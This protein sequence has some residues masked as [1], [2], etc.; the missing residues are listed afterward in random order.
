LTFEEISLCRVSFFRSSPSL[1]FPIGRVFEVEDQFNG[2]QRGTHWYRNEIGLLRGPFS[3]PAH[4]R[5]Y[6]ER[7]SA[8]DGA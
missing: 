5:F 1:H 4:A 3:D 7:E 2:P 6:L 8:D